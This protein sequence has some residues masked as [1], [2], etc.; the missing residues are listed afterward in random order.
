MIFAATLVS[1]WLLGCLGA[2]GTHHRLLYR[3]QVYPPD[4]ER[5]TP[6]SDG[7][8]ADDRQPAVADALT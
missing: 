2:V 6:L 8:H 3:R 4:P 7:W 1:G 5:Q